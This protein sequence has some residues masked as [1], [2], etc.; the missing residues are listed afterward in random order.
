MSDSESGLF[1]STPEA[2]FYLVSDEDA[3]EEL[4]TEK[5]EFLDDQPGV[6]AALELEQLPDSNLFDQ[7]LKQ[8][9]LGSRWGK[10]LSK[11]YRNY[12]ETRIGQVDESVL[13]DELEAQF[14][15]YDADPYESAVLGDPMTVGIDLTSQIQSELD[16]WDQQQF[17]RADLA[18]AVGI[19]DQSDPITDRNTRGGI[20]FSS[21]TPLSELKHDRRFVRASHNLQQLL[22][23]GLDVALIAPVGGPD[24]QE[25]VETTF[26][27]VGSFT[28]ESVSGAEFNVGDE[29]AAAVDEWYDRLRYSVADNRVVE[30][31]V[32]P[33]SVTAYDLPSE[34]WAR[35]FK[36]AI[37]IGLQGV[38]SEKSFSETRFND[39]WE[40]RVSSHENYDQYR[41]RRKTFP[42]VKVTR[43]NDGG[44]HDFALHH[45]GPS[46]TPHVCGLPTQSSNPEEELVDLIERFLDADRVSEQ[47]WQHL[48]GGFER[49][50]ESLDAPSKDL[51]TNALLRRHRRRQQ[52]TPLL[53][54]SEE[55]TDTFN[56]KREHHDYEDEWYEDHW[57]TILSDYKITKQGGVGAIERKQNLQNSLDPECGADTALYYKLERDINNAW[58]YYLD[59]A[60]KEIQQSLPDDQNLSIERR[61]TSSSKILDITVIPTNGEKQTVTV[62][63]L[64]PYSEVYVNDTEVPAATVTNTVSE[65]IDTL[66]TSHQAQ[67]LN[68]SHKE[69]SDVLYEITKMYLDIAEFEQGELVYFDDVI[70]FC[71]SL[72]NIQHIFNTPDEDVEENIRDFLG[73]EDYISCLRS[74][75]KFHRKG[76]DQHGSVKVQGDRYI[77]MEL[78]EQLQ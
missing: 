20:V 38:Y 13:A 47:R 6:Q 55:D 35:H 11:V 51:V 59:S 54:P 76:S 52:L 63:V 61:E 18:A 21:G 53:P 72:S 12:L 46:A 33:A 71:Q 26:R 8:A 27:G 39:M 31:V 9:K 60:E 44:A 64:L 5:V 30:N 70:E 77:A 67:S 2:V 3:A 34:D 4:T 75:V 1:A 37:T 42:E 28:V 62:E 43:K 7:I 17:T 22:L 23:I 16:Q 73:T 65:V 50:A 19:S 78:Q 15:R 36:N 24:E 32:R 56:A 29:I 74:S 25:T 57:A 49:I 14:S 69:T 58:Q 48:L 10:D 66:G 40:Q 41:S 45:E 68:L